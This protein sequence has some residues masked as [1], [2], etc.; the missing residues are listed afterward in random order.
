MP[1]LSDLNNYLMMGKL[2]MSFRRR[3][4]SVM[5]TVNHK[6]NSEDQVLNQRRKMRAQSSWLHF[7]FVTISSKT[8]SVFQPSFSVELYS[9]PA[10]ASKKTVNG[11][12]II[13][14]IHAAE[15]TPDF[16]L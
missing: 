12:Q 1:R 11:E 8:A 15:L 4:F 2:V 13:H 16:H 3:Q 9:V 6:L 5:Y 7:S 10:F 14:N